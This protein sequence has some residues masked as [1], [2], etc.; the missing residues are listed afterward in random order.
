MTNSKR[1]IYVDLAVGLVVVVILILVKTTLIEDSS[2]GDWFNA[3][4][5]EV[6]H[7]FKP[8]FNPEKE[9][10]VVVLDIS[11]LKRESD[12]TTPAKS[13]RE[14]IEAL[15]ESR[16]KAIAIDIDFSPRIDAEEPI[17]T[18]ARAEDDPEFFSYLH[19]ERKKGI[20]VFVGAFGFGPETK[21]WLGLEEYKDLAADIT[22]FDEDTTQVPRWLQCPEGEKLNSLSMSMAEASGV[23]PGPRSWLKRFLKDPEAAESLSEYPMKDKGGRVIPCKRAFTLVNYSKLELM[24]LL[25]VQPLDRRSVLLAKNAEGNSK[26]E[27]KLVIIGNAQRTKASDMFV[28]IGRHKPIP[29]VFLNAAATYTL[30][31]EPIFEFKRSVTITLDL[32]VG[33]FVVGGLFALRFRHRGDAEYSINLSESVLIF[34][35]ILVTVLFG[36]ILVK[37][38]DVLWLD[39]SLVLFALLL[40]SKVQE[41]VLWVPTRGIS[42]IKSFFTRS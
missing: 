39:F 20:P 40:H 25:I 24:Q 13:L 37:A 12:G 36:I 3:F 28:V 29:G 35:L 1:K 15:V 33:L 8:P 16:V 5:Y 26:F 6:L 19:E 22:I 23:H 41:W 34:V 42:K 9:P 14:I 18:G 10:S 30:V 2:Y 4:G 11:D 7:S 31:D 17:K 27:N 21:T 38:L 32:L